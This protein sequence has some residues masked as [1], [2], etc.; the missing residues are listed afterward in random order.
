MK[1][2]LKIQTVKERLERIFQKILRKN[3]FHKQ[4][5]KD[6]LRRK[7][8]KLTDKEIKRLRIYQTINCLI[9]NRFFNQKSFLP[10]K[11]YKWWK[12]WIN[13]KTGLDEYGN[14]V[15]KS[16]LYQNQLKAK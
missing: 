3:W 8:H 10:F 11:S 2:L 9:I 7:R 5:W 6:V 12:L 15:I 14:F 1:I 16:Q 13:N 4:V